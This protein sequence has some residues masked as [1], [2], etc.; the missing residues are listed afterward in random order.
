MI[1]YFPLVLLLDV[2]KECGVAEV[3]LAAGTLVVPGLD[4]DAEVVRVGVMV[5]V[6]LRLNNK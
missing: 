5:H 2:G 6:E 1:C 3:G 4:G